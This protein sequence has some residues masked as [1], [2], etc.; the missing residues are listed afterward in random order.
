MNRI[1]ELRKEKG[2]SV[3]ELC[4]V[5]GICNKSYYNYI[6]GKRDI[7]SSVIKRISILFEVS[8][9]YLLGIKN[10][11]RIIV[12]DNTGGLLAEISYNETI[13]HTDCRVILS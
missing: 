10:Y 2:M 6:S 5:V 12:T 8:A 9:D 3:R 4:E 11:T 7:P 1:D 13:E